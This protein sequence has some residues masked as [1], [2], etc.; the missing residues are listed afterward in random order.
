MAANQP[1]KTTYLAF[2]PISN[3]KPQGTQR[4]PHAGVGNGFKGT[5]KDDG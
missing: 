4:K 5:Q 2:L 3:G 1:S